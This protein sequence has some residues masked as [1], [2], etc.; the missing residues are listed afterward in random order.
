MATETGHGGQG[1]M[2]TQGLAAAALFG[3]SPE[4]MHFTIATTP[5]SL[6][7]QPRIHVLPWQPHQLHHQP[8]L[9][10]MFCHGNH[11]SFITSPSWKPCIL[12]W[13]PHQRHRRPSES[14]NPCILPW[15]PHN[16]DLFVIIQILLP[17]SW[18]ITSRLVHCVVSATH[19]GK[20]CL[21][22]EE[23]WG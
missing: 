3:M 2:R 18:T 9:E 15:Q 8:S 7:A 16:L 12:P 6:S 21:L 5:A 23:N 14:G 1:N 11:I 20:V 4:S 17:V 13:Q 19:M 22:P 10:S